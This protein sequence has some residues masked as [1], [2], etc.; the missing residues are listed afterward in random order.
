MLHETAEQFG[1]EI[2]SLEIADDLVHLFVQCDPKW[3][4]AEVAKQLK[5]YS[6]GHYWNDI[7]NSKR[8]TSGEVVSG[9]TATTSER[10]GTSR[11]T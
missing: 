9:K 1:H 5:G 3:S 10:Q 4:P 7:P 11:P 8:N 6:V 2:F